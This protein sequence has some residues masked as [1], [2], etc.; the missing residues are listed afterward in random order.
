M[1]NIKCAQTAQKMHMQ[2]IQKVV[3]KQHI[4][5]ADSSSA[6]PRCLQTE[7]MSGDFVAEA[8]IAKLQG[9]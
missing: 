9:D 2:G 5:S 4:S 1:C 6:I 8:V 7:T 3:Y